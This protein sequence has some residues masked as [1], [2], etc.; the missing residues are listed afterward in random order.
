MGSVS[1]WKELATYLGENRR[2]RQFLLKG[3]AIV[4]KEHS[5]TPCWLTPG[6]QTPEIALFFS[7]D[8]VG[9]LRGFEFNVFLPWPRTFCIAYVD[10]P[11]LGMISSTAW[12]IFFMSSSGACNGPVQLHKHEQ[13]II[14]RTHAKLIRGEVGT[15]SVSP[16][17]PGLS[18]IRMHFHS[19]ICCCGSSVRVRRFCIRSIQNE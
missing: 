12:L 7:A 2:N 3:L 8:Q 5:L 10:G 1:F 16:H 17:S 19:T 14:E 15:E 9:S 6:V 13:K 4:S 18:G 11:Q